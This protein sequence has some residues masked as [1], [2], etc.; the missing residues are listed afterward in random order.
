VRTR[1][2]RAVGRLSLA[3]L[4]CAWTGVAGAADAV[5]VR[6]SAKKAYDTALAG[7]RDGWTTSLEVVTLPPPGGEAH[8]ALAA[9]IRAASPRVILALGPQAA[10]FAGEHLPEV[11]RVLCMAGAAADRVDRL[12]VVVSSDPS[13]AL[14]LAAYRRVLPALARLTTVYHPGTTGAFVE[15]ATQAASALGIE[16][17]GLPVASKKDVP[18]AVQLAFAR[19]DAVW[20]LRDA[21]VMSDVLLEQTLL[22]QVELRKPVLV[23]ADTFVRAGALAA[24]TSS[25]REQ[26]RQAAALAARILAGAAPD[27][28]EAREARAVLWVNAKTAA[29]L[30][31][32]LPAELT[33]QPDVKLL[34]PGSAGGGRP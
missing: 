2:D 34:D 5:A 4:A 13:P 9:R 14:Q 29:Q 21:V 23:Y 32:V 22:H 17:V 18:A 15:R 31:L 28:L 20:L 27:T 24:Y 6:A 33:G 7:F 30:G 25:Y 16:L 10:A 1:T 26:G 3:L 19:G 11:P 8:E 12:S